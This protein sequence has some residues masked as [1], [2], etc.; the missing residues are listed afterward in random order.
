MLQ[1]G[2]TAVYT[3]SHALAAALAAHASARISPRAEGLHTLDERLGLVEYR[4]H[5]TFPVTAPGPLARQP[6][7][8]SQGPSGAESSSDASRPRRGSLSSQ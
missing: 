5:F 3:P 1:V 7:T 4:V 2:A 6:L 8:C